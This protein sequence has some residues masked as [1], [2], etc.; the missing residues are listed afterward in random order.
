MQ[1]HIRRYDVITTLEHQHDSSTY[2]VN[3]RDQSKRKAILKIFHKPAL[4]NLEKREDFLQRLETLT[5]IKHPHLVPI[6]DGGIEKGNGYI[7]SEYMAGGS[8]RARLDQTSPE[9][10]PFE[11]ALA[12]VIHIGQALDYLHAQQIVHGHLMPKHIFFDA[13]GL[14]LL[15]DIYMPAQV[16]QSV[17]E[18]SRN[19]VRYLA[20]EQCQETNGFQVGTALSDQYT[21]CCIAYEL[22]TGQTPFTA[23]DILELKEQQL[24]MQPASISSLVAELPASV[25]AAIQRGLEKDPLQRHPTLT[26]LLTILQIE[27]Q[28]TTQATLPIRQL[29]QATL[30]DIF[31]LP[32][33]N[34][35]ADAAVLAHATD[36][37]LPALGTVI[38]SAS[39]SPATLKHPSR[40]AAPAQQKKL[41]LGTA[42][43]TIICCLIVYFTLAAYSPP[44]AITHGAT[45]T[46]TAVP[47]IPTPTKASQTPTS[48][49]PTPTATPRSVPT[50]L[51]ITPTISAPAP[52]PIP[53]QQP[54]PVPTSAPQQPTATA[55]AI[56]PL[57]SGQ[58]SAQTRQRDTYSTNLIPQL[59]VGNVRIEATISSQGD[60]GG[61][62]FRSS[63]NSTGGYNFIIRT[64]GNYY[65]MSGTQTIAHSF[66]SAIQTGNGVSNQITI[67]AV[68]SQITIAINA[69]SVVNLS[70]DS[71]S[72]GGVGI[73]A[74]SAYNSTVTTG[75][76][77]IYAD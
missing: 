56:T 6:I 69:Q 75:D 47:T 65:L 42:L 43:L 68:G 54:A 12:L 13:S 67:V 28:T 38:K 76:F 9:R 24:H 11:E 77:S 33:A 44:V 45:Q 26:E 2:L 7:V 25:N 39:Q 34:D 48:T 73:V 22:F 17:Q 19:S 72:S 74:F 10:L 30:T 50:A 37:N 53:T 70:D 59:T 36:H 27:L 23:T 3:T 66:S 32:Q 29:E 62:A 15:S 18:T 16:A 35:Q 58:L 1:H 14:E 40:H 51:A 31:T 61:V 63:Q 60:G 52:T 46:Q 55:T 5:H 20:P 21:L 41:W 8:L 64:N 57:F 71:Y 49:S 4:L